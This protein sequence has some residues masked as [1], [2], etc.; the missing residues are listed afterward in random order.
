LKVQGK[1]AILP[2]QKTSDATAKPRIGVLAIQGDYDA[3]AAA[4][5]D[6][7]AEPVLIRKPDQLAGLDGLII[8]GGESTTFLKFLERDG[9]L[10]SLRTFALAH[11]TFGTCAGCI[12]LATNVLHPP[13]ASLGVLDATVERNAYGRQIDSSIEETA[14]SLGP[15]FD[16][17]PLETVYIRAPRIQ[18]VGK[19]VSI[20]AERD[21]FPVLVRQHHLLAATFHPE[22]SSDRRVHRYFVDMVREATH[23]ERGTYRKS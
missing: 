19:D 11:P 18:Q 13:Q 23:A 12:L 5:S 10:E 1:T 21:G 7:G 22:L 15:T 3:H 6:V 20:L 4:L 8:P 14:T 9:F 2:E 16:T 17:G